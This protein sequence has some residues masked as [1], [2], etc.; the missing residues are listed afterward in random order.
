MK[1]PQFVDIFYDNSCVDKHLLRV[2]RRRPWLRELSWSYSQF[3]SETRDSDWRIFYRDFAI[4]E[5]SRMS[6][7]IGLSSRDET[8]GPLRSFSSDA[9]SQSIL[10]SHTWRRELSDRFGCYPDI[11]DEKQSRP[12]QKASRWS[13]RRLLGYV[14]LSFYSEETGRISSAAKTVALARSSKSSVCFH[15]GLIGSHSRGCRRPWCLILH[16]TS[17]E[18]WT[19]WSTGTPRCWWDWIRWRYRIYRRY[20]LQNDRTLR[21]GAWIRTDSAER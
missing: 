20:Y 21:H 13:S 18:A 5:Q 19:R 3:R 8:D 12:D 17:R 2:C 10:R 6:C 15:V 16:E 11:R 14:G 1:N 7:E 9:S 4:A